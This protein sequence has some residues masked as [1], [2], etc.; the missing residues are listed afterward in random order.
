MLVTLVLL[1]GAHL[2][3]QETPPE[4]EPPLVKPYAPEDALKRRQEL[5][6]LSRQ[7]QQ[8]LKDRPNVSKTHPDDFARALLKLEKC[9]LLFQRYLPSVGRD[10]SFKKELE[11]GQRL[12]R[13][14]AKGEKPVLPTTGMIERAYLSNI[15][16][17]AQPY[18][19]YI[20]KT[21]DL[22]NPA[23]LVI[24]LH[25]YIGNLDKV[26]WLDQTLSDSM[27]TLAE[28]LG[29][30]LLAPF[31]R[32]NTDFLG[33][34]ERDVLK[35]IGLARRDYKIDA[36]RIYL[37][38]PS[39]GGSGAWAIGAHY[40]HLFAANVPASG[41]S[42]YN[43]WQDV[44]RGVLTE[45]KQFIIDR[46]YA[47]TLK[48][49]FRN[50]PVFA[51]HGELDWLVKPDQSRKM[52]EA[53]QA[54]KFEALYR[55]FPE[56]DHWSCFDAFDSDELIAWLRG[57]RRV[58]RPQRVTYRTYHPRFNRAYWVSIDDFAAFGKPASVDAKLTGPQRVT[59]TVE[60]VA[61][62]TLGDGKHLVADDTLRAKLS[63]GR[64]L[65]PVSVTDGRAT[66]TVSPVPEGGLRKRGEL[67]GPVYEAYQRPFVLVYGTA[68][69][70]AGQRNSRNLAS[71]GMLEWF[72]FAAGVPRVKRDVDVNKE[73]IRDFN[74][75]LFGTPKSNRV[76]A[77][78]ADKLPVK[79]GKNQF[80]IGGKTYAG[81]KL[82]LIM[83]YP[84]PL[85]PERM[86]V[87][88]SGVRWGKG[89]PQ[90]HKMDFLP[91]YIVFDDTI[92][93]VSGTNTFKVAGFFDIN[94]QLDTRLMWT[95]PEKAP[96]RKEPDWPENWDDLDAPDPDE[97]EK[98]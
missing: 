58:V 34:G 53:L 7:L 71:M 12:L 37:C 46:D 57:K 68:G 26:N 42:D 95:D 13:A 86:V 19:I 8:L 10:A 88:H 93:P 89:L 83:T 84:N 21:V 6:T 64:L 36:D 5:T 73:D 61:R 66:F 32:S 23:P 38:G 65:K 55:E 16:G 72:E 25:G 43:L 91:D 1:V 17:S 40:P 94:W 98:P 31:A 47:V 87:I 27:K 3:A 51:F 67:C 49:N 70:A 39:M 90:N 30:I 18:Y 20:P 59:V 63:D 22:K 9:A 82:G 11:E 54:L 75:I 96:P 60:N 56:G 80:V 29:G 52:V 28:K 85:N 35:T 45:F 15:D 69:D 76:I 97:P 14:L 2:C 74:L 79:I 62:F 81:E 92:A 24:F 50:L 33:I 48:S 44:P 77:R 4:A 78:I 41:R